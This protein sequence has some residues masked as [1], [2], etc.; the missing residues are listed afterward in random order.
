[1][2][3]IEGRQNRMRGEKIAIVAEICQHRGDPGRGSSSQFAAATVVRGGSNECHMREAA[4]VP[5]AL[6]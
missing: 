2:T 3:G 6:L 4:R 1:M 5:L